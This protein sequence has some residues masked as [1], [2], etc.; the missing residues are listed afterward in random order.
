MKQGSS[1]DTP[2]A[3]GFSVHVVV[4]LVVVGAVS[5]AAF[6]VLS[7]FADDLRQPDRSGAH[8]QSKSAVG[9]AAV[10]ELLRGEGRS[11]SVHRGPPGELETGNALLVITPPTDDEAIWDEYQEAWVDQLIVLPKWS[12]AAR[13][14][15]PQWVRRLGLEPASLVSGTVSQLGFDVEIERDET[16]HS[17]SFYDDETRAGDSIDAGTIESLQTMIGDDLSPVL[18]DDRG[19]MVLGVYDWG[20]DEEEGGV[21]TWVLSDPDLLNTQGLASPKTARVALRIFDL[22]APDR[23]EVVFDLATHGL[24]RPR[25]LLRLMFLPPFLPAVVCLVFAAVLM[26]VHSIS[27]GGAKRKTGRELA[28][29]K[30]AL[31]DNSALLLGLAR[32][33]AR[34]GGRYAAMTRA[35][36]AAAVGAPPGL[37]EEQQAAVL[38]SR[39]RN[40]KSGPS[41]SDLAADVRKAETHAA[42]MRAARRLYS[43]RQELGRD[44]RRR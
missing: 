44:D 35:L 21:L 38:D 42:L 27:G 40:S 1:A 14:D 2:S 23:R 30:K 9:F 43:W 5:L 34:M 24:D 17:V 33:E 28:F 37:S 25:N 8:A 10:T 32:R 12:T 11:V 16:T 36:A 31:V 19:R 20:E 29:G 3:A 15:K 41:F 13:A 22:V 26:A 18:V 6:F 39:A 4:A 7:A